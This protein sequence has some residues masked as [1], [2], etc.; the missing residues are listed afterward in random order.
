MK[1]IVAVLFFMPFILQA[2]NVGI[3]TTTPVTKLNIV[4]SGSSPAIPGTSSTALFRIGLAANEGIDFGKMAVAPFSG[5]IQAGINGSIADPLTLQPQGGNVGIG[6]ISPTAKL[7][8]NGDIKLQGL[9]LFEFGAG[10]AGKEVNAGKIGYNAFGQNA[11]T[12]VGAGTNATNRKIYFFAEGGVGMNGSLDIAGTL[13]L[14]GN[15]GATGQVLTSNGTADPVWRNTALSNSTRFS[16][17]FN[18]PGFSTSSGFVTYTSPIRYNL[19]NANISIGTNSITLTKAGLYHF[20]VFVDAQ[21]GYTS[22]PNVVPSFLAELDLGSSMRYTLINKPF[23]RRSISSVLSPDETF[24]F[25]EL[26]SYDVYVS[27]GA[28]LRVRTSI[29]NPS[30]SITAGYFTGGYITG[31]LISE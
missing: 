8:V 27:A 22:Q 28:V 24:Y 16:V 18:I 11:L 3:G 14:N 6:I 17:N 7:D 2:Q 25:S 12:F 31:H 15:P 1:K 26:V 5:W 13:K 10:V 19:D 23:P 20:Q 30:L 21:M 9:N 4:G 29:G